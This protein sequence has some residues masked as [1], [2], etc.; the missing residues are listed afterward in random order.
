MYRIA[1]WMSFPC[2]QCHLLYLSY[3]LDML[4]TVQ[5]HTLIQNAPSRYAISCSLSVYLFRIDRN[6][7]FDSIT[8][9]R[10]K[11]HDVLFCYNK[12]DKDHK[13]I[14][15][16]KTGNVHNIWSYVHYRF[17]AKFDLS[18][19]FHMENWLMQL[20]V[21]QILKVKQYYIYIFLCLEN[22]S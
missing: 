6:Q 4:S 17:I 19:Y 21:T 20:Q 8:C 12:K 1:H 18:Y 13:I 3:L 14:M 9:D 16:I 22:Q 15:P 11:A 5:I 10:N 7:R 2:L